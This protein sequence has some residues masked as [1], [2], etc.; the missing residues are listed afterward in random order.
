MSCGVYYIQ[1]YAFERSAVSVTPIAVDGP[2]GVP[3]AD[4]L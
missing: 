1:W 4:T 2:L 3:P